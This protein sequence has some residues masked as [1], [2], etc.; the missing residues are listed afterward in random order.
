MTANFNLQFQQSE[1]TE[2][3]RTFSYPRDDKKAIKAGEQIKSGHYTLTNLDEIAKW[4]SP[5][6]IR[7]VLKNSAADVEEALRV[8]VSAKTDRTAM[9]VLIGLRG[10]DVPVGSAVLSMIDPER[11]TIVDFRALAALGVARR[12]APSIDFY[13]EYLVRCRQLAS[14]YGVSMRT[15][16]KAMWQWSKESKKE[17]R[18]T[19]SLSN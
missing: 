9:A 14:D 1:I 3:A 10:I 18:S 2:L 13:L 7:H 16:D 15:L 19:Q 5:R 8:A 4:K 17:R 11:F 12:A 6:S